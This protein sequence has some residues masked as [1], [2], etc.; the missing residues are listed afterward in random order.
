M[1]K[2]PTPSY[3]NIIDKITTR[4]KEDTRLSSVSD[5]SIF[6]GENQARVVDWPTITVSLD[7]VDEE[8]RTFAGRTGGQK[9][10]TCTVRLTVLDRVA[11]GAA[12]Y[13][14]GLQSVENIV[15]IVDD[16]IQSDVTISGVAYKSE[17][18]T[19]TF[20]MGKYDNTPVLGAEI[21]LT[22]VVGFTRAS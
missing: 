4:L 6:A 20:T 19:K 15:R 18:A 17:T 14:E 5:A 7:R 9:N 12:G 8:W 1:V 13:L 22:T 11:H 21:E 3:S 16:I 10:A 2:I